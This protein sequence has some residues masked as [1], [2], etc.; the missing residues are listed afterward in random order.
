[1]GSEQL[2]S[3]EYYVSQQQGSG[4]CWGAELLEAVGWNI[5]VQLPTASA[6]TV[7]EQDGTLVQLKT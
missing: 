3:S 6:E 1:M 4:N 2:Q 5:L 7:A